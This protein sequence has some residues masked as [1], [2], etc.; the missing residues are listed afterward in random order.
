MLVGDLALTGQCRLRVG[1]SR[2]GFSTSSGLKWP[3]PGSAQS[4]PYEWG[5]IGCSL[6]RKGLSCVCV[7]FLLAWAE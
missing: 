4:W 3:Q 2:E 7:C 1:R 5:P 6:H